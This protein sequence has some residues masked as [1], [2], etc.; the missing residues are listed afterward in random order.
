MEEQLEE[1]QGQLEYLKEYK[2]K[3]L[4]DQMEESQVEEQIFIEQGPGE[5]R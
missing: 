3:D 5:Q 1:L 2:E 4:P